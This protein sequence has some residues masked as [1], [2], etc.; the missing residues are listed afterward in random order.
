MSTKIPVIW[1]L[2]VIQFELGT[3]IDGIALVEMYPSTYPERFFTHQAVAVI[4]SYANKPY[5]RRELFIVAAK[6][7][8]SV[9]TK[10]HGKFSLW[11]NG[12]HVDN[13]EIYADPECNTIVPT[14]QLYPTY[15][16]LEEQRIEIISD[17]DDTII[18]SFTGSFLRRVSTILFKQ[19]KSRKMVDFTKYLIIKARESGIRVYCI[20][21]SEVNLF[22]LLTNI[23]SLNHI[24]GVI[25]YLFDYLN[26]SELLTVTKKH[27]KFEQI[28]SILQKSPGKR[29][30][31]IGDDTQNDIRTYSEVAQQF[32]GRICGVFIHKTKAYYSRFQKFYYERLLRLK[33]PIAYFDDDT[34]FDPSILKNINC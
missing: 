22:H 32:P 27:F 7:V 30:Y 18:Q 14:V 25:I 4:R 17:I 21:R 8:Y 26:Y 11:L 19:P 15:Y 23:L 33:I 5:A 9:T 10:N 28:C 16:P 6:K 34:R 20:S 3:A 31:L 12:A 2:S 29:F 13:V 1:E 24:S